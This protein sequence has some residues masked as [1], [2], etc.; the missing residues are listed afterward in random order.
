MKPRSDLLIAL[1]CIPLLVHYLSCSTVVRSHGC[2]GS[3]LRLD[4]TGVSLHAVDLPGEAPT[5]PAL[6]EPLP[7]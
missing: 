1:T 3:R 7:S 4:F 6:P 2:T 5:G